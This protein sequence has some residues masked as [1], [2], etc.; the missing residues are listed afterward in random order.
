MCQPLC[1][2]SAVKSARATVPPGSAQ[3]GARC[4][5][6]FGRGVVGGLTGRSRRRG[7]C[8]PGPP[9]SCT[10]SSVSRPRRSPLRSPSHFLCR[11]LQACL[12]P[13]TFCFSSL[14]GALVASSLSG[15][16]HALSPRWSCSWSLAG[17]PARASQTA[18]QLLA[19]LLPCRSTHFAQAFV[20]RVDRAFSSQVC[21]LWP[22]TLEKNEPPPIS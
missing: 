5:P 9:Y 11:C 7:A 10:Q 16:L 8:G 19:L 17:V 2:V 6:V 3:K 20:S 18:A 1:T 13:W 14:G 21:R 22:G 12:W 4:I 15:T